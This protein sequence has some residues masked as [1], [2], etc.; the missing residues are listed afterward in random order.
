MGDYCV[1]YERKGV[2]NSLSTIVDGRRGRLKPSSVHIYRTDELYIE[3]VGI[4][5]LVARPAG[6]LIV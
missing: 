3:K 5:I 2:C 1:R 6:A 4:T